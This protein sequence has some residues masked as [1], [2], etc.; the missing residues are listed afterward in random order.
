MIECQA[1]DDLTVSMTMETNVSY[2]VYADYDTNA[3]GF[4]FAFEP[5]LPKDRLWNSSEVRER[6]RPSQH[7]PCPHPPLRA[8]RI[9]RDQ[10]AVCAQQRRD[11]GRWR[12]YINNAARIGK[13]SVLVRVNGRA[14]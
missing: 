9:Y 6:E 10:R 14:I 7:T 1:R 2:T 8:A 5:P 11:C 3:N 4:T 13:E 12:N